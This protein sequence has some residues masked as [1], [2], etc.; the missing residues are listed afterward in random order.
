MLSRSRLRLHEPHGHLSIYAAKN[1]H[2]LGLR[3]DTVKPALILG[4][5]YLR[6]RYL[7]YFTGDCAMFG[8]V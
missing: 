5:N 8:N 4:E 2:R 3:T 1:T 6:I 7:I